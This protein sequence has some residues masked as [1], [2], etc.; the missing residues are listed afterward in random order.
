MSDKPIDMYLSKQENLL[1]E[2]IRRSL[3]AETKVALLDLAIQ[4]AN[5]KAGESSEQLGN[6]TVALEQALDG[7]KLV[8]LERDNL[9]E[10]LR[11][12]EKHLNDC[13]VTSTKL[14]SDSSESIVKLNTVLND[15][16]VLKENYNRVCEELSRLQLANESSSLSTARKKK[17]MK[18]DSEWSDG[19]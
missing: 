5:K 4:E 18:Q 14:N 1:I 19:E 17:P 3:Q 6:V 12:V 2:F 16:T 11:T 7:L 9:K 8:T 10:K 13:L 15:Y